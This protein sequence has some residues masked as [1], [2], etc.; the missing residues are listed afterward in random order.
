MRLREFNIQ[1]YFASWLTNDPGNLGHILAEDVYYSECYGPE[2]QGLQQVLKWFHDW[3]KR[4]TV[5]E[6]QIKQCIHEG[7]YTV[8]E[9]YFECEF[10]G[11]CDEFDG[12]SIVLFNSCGKIVSLKEFQSKSKHYQPYGEC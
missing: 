8:V 9:W 1:K 6:W 3:N 10:D 4:G 11:V 2:Y 12:V 5:L 7:N